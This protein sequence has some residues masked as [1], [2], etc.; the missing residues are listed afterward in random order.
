MLKMDTHTKQMFLSGVFV[1]ISTVSGLVFNYSIM[2]ENHKVRIEQLEKSSAES[3]VALKILA[4]DTN[5]LRTKNATVEALL[6]NLNKSVLQ[7]RDTTVELG[8]IATR[9]DE[10]SKVEK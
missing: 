9:L 3:V 10:R 4:E 8:K 7:L 1:Y 2:Q 5:S 6:I